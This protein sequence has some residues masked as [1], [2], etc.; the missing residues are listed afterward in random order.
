MGQ[1][2]L[3]YV[4]PVL[5]VYVDGLTLSPD[6]LA[7]SAARIREWLDRH[8]SRIAFT[9]RHHGRDGGLVFRDIR[10]TLH[11]PNSDFSGRH[12]LQLRCTTFES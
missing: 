5:G 9:Y 8:M 6:N 12:R 7:S 2:R 10:F 3:D 11:Y 4:S 1:V